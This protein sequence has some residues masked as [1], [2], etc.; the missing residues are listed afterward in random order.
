M[1]V[2][3]LCVR[4]YICGMHM[5]EVGVVYVLKVCEGDVCKGDVR[6]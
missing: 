3:G 1:C 4:W 5:I 2:S 6:D